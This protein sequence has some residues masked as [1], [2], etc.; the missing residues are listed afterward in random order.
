[1]KQFLQDRSCSHFHFAERDTPSP[2]GKAAR[3]RTRAPGPG[4]SPNPHLRQH[5][6]WVT[7]NGSQQPPSLK[8]CPQHMGTTSPVSEVTAGGGCAS[9]NQTR[10]WHIK[11]QLLAS[12]RDRLFQF[13]NQ[14][15]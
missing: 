15:Y 6:P 5:T 4:A 9:H 12:W 7:A 10:T 2:R 3:P 1:M 8:N 14:Y 11:G 13:G